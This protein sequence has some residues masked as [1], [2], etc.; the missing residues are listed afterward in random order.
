MSL[1]Y[2]IIV[3]FIFIILLVFNLK[4]KLK[5]G[6]SSSRVVLNDP[7]GYQQSNW[8]MKNREDPL[9]YNKDLDNLGGLITYR[10]E[11]NHTPTKYNSRLYYQ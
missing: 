9:K 10:K 4:N 7:F 11:M 1:K 6:F 3:I 5:E 8:I 2:Y